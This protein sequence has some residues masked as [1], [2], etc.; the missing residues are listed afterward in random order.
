MIIPAAFLAACFT[1]FLPVASVKADPLLFADQADISRMTAYAIEHHPQIQQLEA[2]V[3]AE[4]QNFRIQTG[5][6]DPMINLTYFPEP[7]ETRLGPQDYNIVLSQPIPFPGKLSKKGEVVRQKIVVAKHRLEQAARD[8][9][10]QVVKAVAELQYIREAQVI[11]QENM[12]LIDALTLEAEQMYVSDQGQLL[13]MMRAGSQ[14]GQLQYDLVLLEERER[15]Q[16]IE[17]NT[18]MNRDPMDPIGRLAGLAVKPLALSRD[19]I[20]DLALNNSDAVKISQARVDQA[21]TEKELAQYAFKPDFRVG[22][23][24]AGIGDSEFNVKD[25]GKDALGVQFGFNIPLWSGKNRAKGNLALQKER[26][27]GAEKVRIRNR[28]VSQIS[29]LHFKLDNAS[30][31]MTLYGNSLIPQALNTLTLTQTWYGEG[32]GSFGD[33]VEAQSVV[34]NF[35]L[36]LVRART[37]YTQVLADMERIAGISLAQNDNEGAL[38]AT[39]SQNERNTPGWETNDT[40]GAGGKLTPRK[41]P[42]HD[43][44]GRTP[45][46]TTRIYPFYNIEDARH[47]AD[48]SLAGTG[49]SAQALVKE[50]FTLEQLE[51]MLLLRNAGVRSAQLQVLAVRDD[52]AQV[53][54]LEDILKQYAAFTE[55]LATGTGPVRGQ[56]MIRTKYPFPGVSGLKSGLVDLD[57][58]AAE[59]NL[60]IRKRDAVTTLRKVYWDLVYNH[61]ARQVTRDMILKFEQLREVAQRLYQSGKSTF[62]DISSID[63]RVAV[64]SEDL[65]SLGTRQ[66]QLEA[67]LISL[68]NLP[69]GT[70]LGKPRIDLP[71]VHRPPLE[72]LVRLGLEHRQELNRL[73]VKIDR[74]ALM[75]EM[76]ETMSL[77]GYS[78]DFSNNPDKAVTQTGPGAKSAFKIRTM[79]SKGY[80]SPVRPF[81]GMKQA[82]LEQTRKSK[83]AMEEMLAQEVHTLESRLSKAWFDLDRAIR[84]TL[85]YQDSIMDLSRSSLEVTVKG[86]ESGKLSFPQVISAYTD[87]LDTSLKL[88]RKHTRIGIV[89]AGIDQL[90]GRSDSAGILK[91]TPNQQD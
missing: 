85:L 33:L 15:D 6:P 34:H 87:W 28:V 3:A 37:D 83:A 20:F 91:N 59:L 69:A 31:L 81:Y 54:G 35:Q 24:Y 64:L 68:L 10:T 26:A 39:A 4:T 7:I 29:N 75:I 18:L 12:A 17:L 71:Q 5:Y 78:L 88:V 2:Q 13:D 25:S 86:Y 1:A 76:A 70:R 61:N 56:D 77:P 50:F 42:M 67:D 16:V 14:K 36:S 48:Q 9:T 60:E 53:N 63:I 21:R 47:N 45:P 19:E 62:S 44:L 23:F 80:G 55:S 22:L 49:R 43:P 89:T 82:W 8:V 38:A 66:K 41:V 73:R 58:K 72:R 84:E 74:M 32:L 79:A 52:Y 40:E 30:R 51:A 27:A 46:E 90:A 65:I 11:A 57:V